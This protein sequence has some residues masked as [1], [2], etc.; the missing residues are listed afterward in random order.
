M[1]IFDGPKTTTTST[2][3]SNQET[4][5][6]SSM[7]SSQNSLG[8][9]STNP[10]VPDWYNQFLV[11][12]P[13][14]FQSLGN[15]FGQLANHPLFG[16]P[17]QANFQENLNRSALGAQNNV[18][19]QLAKSGALNSGRAAT[20][21]MG[22]QNNKTNQLGNYL[23]NATLQNAQF[24]SSQLQNQGNVLNAA[25]NFK[26]PLGQTSNSSSNVTANQFNDLM[27]LLTGNSSGTQTSQQSGGLFQSLLSGLMSSG[28]SALTGGLTSAFTPN[29]S[30]SVGG[31][32]P[33]SGYDP[34]SYRPSGFNV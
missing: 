5:Q 4:N 23:N 19:S 32:A 2:N 34:G 22:I 3:T 24:K 11:N 8:F 15:Q 20:S 28:L 18:M 29:T 21:L 1:G 26:I 12:M 9:N 17:Q 14:Q 33:F 6:H 13:G 27:S 7:D 25:S 16:A 10:N 30:G 31:Q